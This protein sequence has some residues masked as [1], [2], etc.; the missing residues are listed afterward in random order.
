MNVGKSLEEKPVMFKHGGDTRLL[1]HYFGN[2]NAV[3][4]AGFA[5]REIAPIFVV[6][7]E[8]YAAKCTSGFANGGRDRPRLSTKNALGSG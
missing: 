1:Q 7:M 5:P 8:K 2:P 4:V 6:P 3:G